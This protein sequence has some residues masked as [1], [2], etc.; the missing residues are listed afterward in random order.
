MTFEKWL[1]SRL[2]AHGAKIVVDGDIG[3]ATVAAM[4]KFQTER[5]LPVTGFADAATVAALRTDRLPATTISAE[6]VPAATLP[7]WMYE[8]VRRMGLHEV[9]DKAALTEFLKIEK[10]LG[11]PA[12]LPWCGDAVES[13]IAKALPDERIPSAPFFAQNWKSF[14][15]EVEPMVGAVG[16][17]AWSS[18]AGHVG[19][20][21]EVTPS[22]IGMVGGNQSNRI[23]NARFPRSKFI[24]FRWPASYPVT[25]YPTFNGA[26]ADAGGFAGTR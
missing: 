16:V 20:V 23:S 6:P 3:R 12:R 14:G 15:R 22:Q 17:I 7:P 18:S 25:S 9:H 10:F 19:F 11:D 24:A 4:K 1:Q 5:N 8:L 2:V 13:A 21:S 26:T